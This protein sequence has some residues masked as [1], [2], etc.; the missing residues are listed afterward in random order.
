MNAKSLSR[1]SFEFAREALL[2]VLC[3]FCGKKMNVLSGLKS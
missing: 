2:C 3:A 1:K